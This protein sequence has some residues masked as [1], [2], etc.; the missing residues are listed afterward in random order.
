[1]KQRL[2]HASCSKDSDNVLDN[3]LD[4]LIQM[5]SG[6]ST[7]VL[8]SHCSGLVCQGL[9]WNVPTIP[10]G[11]LWSNFAGNTD[12]ADDGTLSAASRGPVSSK[13]PA[14]SS[15]SMVLENFTSVTKVDANGGEWCP[16]QID[17]DGQC[18]GDQVYD[19]CGL[20]G[21]ENYCEYTVVGDWYFNVGNGFPDSCN[22]FGAF[23]V[24]FY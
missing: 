4:L 6:L 3:K 7:W 19:A 14:S 15:P 20:C 17:C 13:P 22:Y 23:I 1:M 24:S 18:F 9:C 11:I 16:D 12:G 2:Y 21:G 10:P 8:N 5:V